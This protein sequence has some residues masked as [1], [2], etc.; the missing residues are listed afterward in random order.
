MSRR[1]LFVT[2]TYPTRELDRATT[3]LQLPPTAA[4]EE[5][6][7]G[8]TLV[9][10]MVVRDDVESFGDSPLTTPEYSTRQRRSFHSTPQDDDE[11]APL[12]GNTWYVPETPPDAMLPT[13]A[14]RFSPHR[15]AATA[16][17]QVQLQ[18]QARVLVV[19]SALP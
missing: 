7:P 3:T 10:A 9:A 5:A 13:D 15:V 17:L 18:Q 16:A 4:A 2:A 8:A 19:L 11:P 6:A 1:E 14:A 12:S